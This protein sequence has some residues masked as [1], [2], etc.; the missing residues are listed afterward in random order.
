[1]S[2]PTLYSH[3]QVVIRGIVSGSKGALKEEAERTFVIEESVFLFA[4]QGLIRTDSLSVPIRKKS[5]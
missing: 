5:S 4:A 1:M 3:I 2:F